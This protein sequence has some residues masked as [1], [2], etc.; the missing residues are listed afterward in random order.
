[1]LAGP[2]V[3]RATFMNSAM[4]DMRSD[5]VTKPTAGMRRAIAE[6]EV[7]DD[8]SGEDPTVN[9][10]EAMMAELLEKEA[11][12]YACSGTQSNQMAVRTHCQPGDELLIEAGGHIANFEQ[13]APA[14]LS[15][16]TSRLIKGRYGIIDQP[17][18]EGMIR[19]D[20]QHLAISRLV[21]LENTTNS[22]GGR[23]Y[24]QENID[25]IG[26]WAHDHGL[27]VH[28]DGA[29]LFNAVIAS[30]T[31]A[32]RISRHADTVSICFSKG[33]GCPMG[34]ILIGSRTDIARARRVRKLFGGAL[35]QAGIV[36]ASAIYAIENHVERLAIDHENARV[37]AEEI[38]QI[39]GLTLDPPDVQT[40]LVFFNVD[41]EI[42]NAAQLSA[43]LKA[44]GVR[45]NASGPQRLR[46]CTH[47]DVDRE[48]V[49]RAAAEVAAAVEEGFAGALGAE[50]GPYARG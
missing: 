24:P 26:Q 4:I 1:M 34:S 18:L 37:F 20:N 10:L 49:L 8:M 21:C 19:A 23:V 15:G 44:R 36:A 27:K 14:A 30:G 39:D 25:R 31:S 41:P 22:G 2:L 17:D 48:R 38:R 11:A 16:V 5:T 40:N 28:V 43:K 42:G 45:I 32:A 47:L 46:A 3:L 12:V 29:R 9:R 6:A 7:G 33:L 35:R 50:L 13:G